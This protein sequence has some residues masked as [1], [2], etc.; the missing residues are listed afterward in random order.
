VD[1][2]ARGPSASNA[3]CVATAFL[4]LAFNQNQRALA[5]GILA[6]DDITVGIPE[7]IRALLGVPLDAEEMF[8]DWLIYNIQTQS[9]GHTGT[10]VIKLQGQ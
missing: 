1:C 8:G 10:E 4:E 6:A 2:A 5:L 7:L 9:V 3:A